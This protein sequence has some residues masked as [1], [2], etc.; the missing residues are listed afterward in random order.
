MQLHRADVFVILV[1][2]AARLLP[3]STRPDLGYDIRVLTVCQG[4]NGER[5]RPI[6]SCRMLKKDAHRQFESM[7]F[8]GA[9]IQ[10]RQEIR[11]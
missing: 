9:F 6:A 3:S 7:T 8:Q 10:P 1:H 4:K 5:I 11:S 2:R